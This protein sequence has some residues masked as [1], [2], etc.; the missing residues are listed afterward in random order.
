V[1][2][3]FVDIG[4]AQTLKMFRR[5]LA[6]T[7]L[8]LNLPDLDFSALSGPARQLTQEAARFVYEQRAGGGV[9]L[10]AGIRYTSRLHRTWECWAV[11]ADRLRLTAPRVEFITA[12]DPGLLQAASVLGLRVT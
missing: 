1:Q 11:F 10:Y 3:A 9:P 8:T 12:Q 7:A 2:G 4:D 5:I 6:P